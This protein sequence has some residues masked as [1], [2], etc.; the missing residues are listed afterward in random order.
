M[1]ARN[2]QQLVEAVRGGDHAAYAQLFERY[3][4][5]CFDVAR[6]I[7]H[8]DGRAADVTQEVFTVAWQQ[9]GSLRDPDAFG[10]WVL[11]SSRNKA[12]NTLRD[13]GRSA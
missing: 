7:V 6:R 5:R 11:R 12:L 8:D 2:D 1:D 3:A 4:D 10:G 13:E 9:I